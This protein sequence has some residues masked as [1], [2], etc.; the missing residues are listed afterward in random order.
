M[1]KMEWESRSLEHWRGMGWE[2]RRGFQVRLHEIPFLHAK[3]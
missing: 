3:C 1:L 2:W